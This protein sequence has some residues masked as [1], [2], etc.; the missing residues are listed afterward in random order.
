MTKVINNNAPHRITLSLTLNPAKDAVR[1]QSSDGDAAEIRVKDLHGWDS[2]Q[3]PPQ[4]MLNVG[5]E[6]LSDFCSGQ[7][8]RM[9]SKRLWGNQVTIFY[10]LYPNEG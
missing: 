3:E 10:T 8:V 7:D 6:I 1:I 4:A 9:M 2:N 5:S